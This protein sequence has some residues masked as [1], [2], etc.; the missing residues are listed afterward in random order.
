MTCH[1]CVSFC[2]F[3]ITFRSQANRRWGI[4]HVLYLLSSLVWM[5]H[6]IATSFSRPNIS[7]SPALL[8]VFFRHKL[9]YIFYS[10]YLTVC[11]FYSPAHIS[12]VLGLRVMDAISL[13]IKYLLIAAC[14]ALR[15]TAQYIN[16][17]FHLICVSIICLYSAWKHFSLFAIRI[18]TSSSWSWPPPTSTTNIAHIHTYI[19]S[20]RILYLRI[21]RLIII[22]NEW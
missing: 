8:L 21:L 22:K 7:F 2:Q 5:K 16:I 20:L 13:T 10:T 4:S 11:V 9:F 15:L 18:P 17:F 14:V 6:T 19:I 3:K 12:N 1:E